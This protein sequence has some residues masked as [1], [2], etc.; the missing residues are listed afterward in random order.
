MGNLEIPFDLGAVLWV[1][2]SN[3]HA[4]RD[5]CP[6]CKGGKRVT[7]IL[8]DGSVHLVPCEGCRRGF[9]AP[10]GWVETPSYEYA[11]T[12]FSCDEVEVYGSRVLYV[13]RTRSSRVE[14]GDLFTDKEACQAVC[15]LKNEAAEQ[16]RMKQDL[17]RAKLR[18]QD[19]ASKVSYFRREI[20]RHEKELIRYRGYL[21]HL[22][23]EG[24]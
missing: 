7:V 1:A 18:K 12:L 22:Q 6:D 5:L 17:L 2:S 3:K 10:T 13:D 15:A 16:E 8:G 21:G 11:P 9:E 20:R 23:P 19:Y 24:K 14:A 4:D